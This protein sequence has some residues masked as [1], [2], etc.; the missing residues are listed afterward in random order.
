MTT[1]DYFITISKEL[2]TFNFKVVETICEGF[3]KE[4]YCSGESFEVL[5]AEKILQ[6]LR[7]KRLFLLMQQVGDALIQTGRVSYK[8]RRQYAQALID[9]NNLTA[10]MVVLKELI[11]DTTNAQAENLN[12]KDENAEARGLAGRV[13]K[14]LYVNANCPGTTTSINYIKEAIKFYLDVYISEP[15][16]K[17]WHGINAVALIKRAAMDN[18]DVFGVPDANDMAESILQTINLK[19]ADNAADPWDFA[20]AS[21]AC[22][23]LNKPADALEWMSGYARMPG[24]DAFELGSTLRQLKEVWRLDINSS[25]GKLILPILNAELLKRRGGGQTF[26]ASE[27]K[28][29]KKEED[30]ISQTYNSLIKPRREKEPEKRPEKVF[31]NDSF[32]TYTLYMKGADRC[33]AVARIGKDSSEGVGTGFLLKGRLLREDLGDELVLITNSHVVSNDP[34]E[35]ALRVKEAVIT[36]HVLGAEEFKGYEIIWS[37]PSNELDATLIRF[38]PEDIERLSVLTKNV[39]IYPVSE[40]LPVIDE[41]GPVQRIYVIGHPYGG[42]LRLSS[43]NN[44]LL[45]CKDP[46]I[47]YRTATDNGSSGSPVFNEVW[48]LIGLH[49]AGSEEMEGLES[50]A[51]IYEANEGI[52]IQAIK[53]AMQKT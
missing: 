10:A 40:Y 25:A 44:F 31:G 18:I 1:K 17:T 9:Q 47:H 24:C 13:Y 4:L 20:T 33:A 37:S 41:T 51:E 52:C 26:D 22:V 48:D 32:E 6:Q 14:Q 53:R 34:A 12:A 46:K 30:E 38:A 15:E 49:H 36:F 21:E 39:K 28:N 11:T 7:N 50:T 16:S 35:K 29:L 23:A 19:Y 5:Y 8:V 45:G 43:E 3:I 42:P 27:L 2:G